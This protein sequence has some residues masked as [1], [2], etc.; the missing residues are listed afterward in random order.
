MT[1]GLSASLSPGPHVCSGKVLLAAL[2][3]LSVSRASSLPGSFKAVSLLLGFGALTTRCLVTC[4][5][6]CALRV[7]PESVLGGL[8]QPGSFLLTSSRVASAPPP[9]GGCGSMCTEKLFHRSL[10][11]FSFAEVIF[12][13]GR[14]LRP[15][16]ALCPS[17]PA[18]SM[19]SAT[20]L[21]LSRVLPPR[22]LWPSALNVLQGLLGIF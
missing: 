9:W 6:K 2:L 18:S 15:S 7:P 12:H 17:S 13:S 3:G 21:I 14:L 20:L 16:C 8:C 19:V 10:K 1:V 11:P 4:A 5:C 22:A